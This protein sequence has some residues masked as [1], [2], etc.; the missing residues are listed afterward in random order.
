MLVPG[1]NSTAWQIVANE[2]R[3]TL[4]FYGWP[5]CH[6]A[7]FLGSVVVVWCF[8]QV[9]HHKLAAEGRE[10]EALQAGVQQVGTALERFRGL[11]AS[12]LGAQ[13]ELRKLREQ[14][15]STRLHLE[16]SLASL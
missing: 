3:C 6:L 15:A 7:Y 9:L 8:L 5:H 16:N 10:V 11:P 13:L 2:V 14:L 12:M 1:A 4:A